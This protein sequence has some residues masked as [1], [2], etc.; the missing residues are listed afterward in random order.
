MPELDLSI[1]IV[2]FNTLEYLKNCLDS[3]YASTGVERYEVIVVDNCS[4]D[5]SP[6]MVESAFPPVKLIKPGA[7][8]G[9]ACANNLGARS[10]H[11]RYLLFLN[12]DTVVFPE[13]FSKMVEFMDKKPM[14][15]A[16]N[17]R[18][19]NEDGSVQLLATRRKPTVPVLFLESLG[20]NRRFPNN[21]I[22]RKYTMAGWDRSDARTVDVISGAFFMIRVNL[23]NTLCGF[24]ERFFMYVEDLEL[25]SRVWDSGYEIWFNSETKVIHFGGKASTNFPVIATIKGINAIY[26]FIKYFKVN[27]ISYM[28]ISCMICAFLIRMY[29]H[30]IKLFFFEDGINYY[31]LNNDML[32]T[33]SLLHMDEL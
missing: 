20:I 24:N 33:K 10:A 3:I 19:L 5:G 30:Y 17:C 4:A 32:I 16:A 21:P 2:S 31:T 8:L 15:G 26:N 1:I 14:A 11:G 18:V 6:E 23:F 29:Y 12:P 27:I 28:Y 13:T 7:N 22:N 25:C 9:F